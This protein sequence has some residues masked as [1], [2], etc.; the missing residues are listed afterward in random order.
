MDQILFIGNGLNQVSDNGASWNSLLN[1]IAGKPKNQHEQDIRDKKPFTL[2]YEEL[3]NKSM[4]KKLNLFVADT[5][6][7]GIATH[8][9]H[10]ELMA[11]NFNKILTTNYDYTLE[12]AEGTEWQSDNTA[13]ESRYSLFRRQRSGVKEIWHIH[14]EL[15][16]PASIMLGHEQY[17]GYLH[18]IRNYLTV[19]VDTSLKARQ[20]KPYLSKF[21]GGNVSHRGDIESWVDHFL[22]AEVHMVGFS[23]DYTENHLWNLVI[24]K[25]QLRKQYSTTVGKLIFHRCSNKPQSIADKARLSLLES[26]G[27]EVIDHRKATYEDAYMNCIQSLR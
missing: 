10:V 23:F 12:K 27:T 20:A 17:L 14:G 22:A 9:C 26:F 2:W 19:G 3:R 8:K 24:R 18:K 7:R 6:L 1:K 15:N 13:P 5:L 25:Q 16:N 4:K 11:L 21:A